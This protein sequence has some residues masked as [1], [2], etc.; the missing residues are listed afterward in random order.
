[1]QA[2]FSLVLAAA[3]LFFGGP[4]Q[5]YWMKVTCKQGGFTVD[6]PGTPTV[7]P[8][9]K[10]QSRIGPIKLHMYTLA[11][12]KAFYYVSFADAPNGKMESAAE[13]FRQARNRVLRD[14]KAKLVSERKISLGKFPGSEFVAEVPQGGIVR[15]RTYRGVTRGYQIAIATPKEFANSPDIAHFLDSFKLIAK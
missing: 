2:T 15:L 6:M 11:S 8:E 1:M 5:R 7:Q 3:S 9:E 4:D 12:E 13:T 14:L 10:L